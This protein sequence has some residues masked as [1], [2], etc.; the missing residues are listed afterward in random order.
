MSDNVTYDYL[1][2][3]FQKEKQTNQLLLV[4][5]TFYEDSIKFINDINY[6]SGSTYTKEISIKLLNDFFEKRKQKILIY[7]AYNKQLPQPISSNETEFYNRLLQTVKSERLDF[8]I[9]EKHIVSELKS[10]KDIPEIILPS[11]NKIGPL[12]KDQIVNTENE[13]DIKYLIENTICE[14][15]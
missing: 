3:A 1:W 10:I 14:K 15:I 11:G 9:Q 4:P 5:K 8:T 12:A 2:Q 13:Q 7:V 6:D